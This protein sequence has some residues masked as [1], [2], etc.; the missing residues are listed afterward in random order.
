MTHTN[1]N[2]DMLYTKKRS[3]KKNKDGF[4]HLI[5]MLFNDFRPCVK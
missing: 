5:Q 3:L 1:K 4:R 2:N